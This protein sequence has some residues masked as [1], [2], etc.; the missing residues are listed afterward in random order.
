MVREAP[1]TPPASPYTK[2]MCFSFLGK[3]CPNSPLP[4]ECQMYEDVQV[5]LQR[6]NS[7]RSDQAIAFQ[8]MNAGEAA[9]AMAARDR[10]GLNNAQIQ[11]RMT[12]TRSSRSW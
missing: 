3:V 6:K 4:A 11:R 12:N 5:A 7:N 9:A 8:G 1:L 10:G 2:K